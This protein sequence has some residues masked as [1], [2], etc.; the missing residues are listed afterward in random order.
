MYHC[1]SVVLYLVSPVDGIT[2]YGRYQTLHVCLT[3]QSRDITRPRGCHGQ[4][5]Y[6]H[7]PD[8]GLPVSGV[9]WY[10]NFIDSTVLLL[11]YC[12]I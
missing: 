10:W 2:I 6:L 11:Q 7:G 5:D 1:Y 3:G 9:E 4:P 12:G 8:G